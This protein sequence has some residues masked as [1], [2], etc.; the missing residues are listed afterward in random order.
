[1]I[2]S[3]CINPS[4]LVDDCGGKSVQHII[5]IHV[6]SA[7]LFA[8][9]VERHANFSL[10]DAALI[11]LMLELKKRKSKKKKAIIVLRLGGPKGRKS[12]PEELH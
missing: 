11:R 5:S 4:V 6:S 12:P 10:P 9:A 1:M 7:Q 2:H 8:G 3:N